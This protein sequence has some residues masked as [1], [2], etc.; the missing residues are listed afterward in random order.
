MRHI[1]FDIEG[2]VPEGT[3]TD[4]ALAT[5]KV[6]CIVAQELESGELGTWGPD[7][8]EAGIAF[9]ARADVLYGHNIAKY[10]LPVFWYLHGFHFTGKVYCT[11]AASHLIYPGPKTMIKQDIIWCRTHPEFPG[12]MI[13]R[14]SLE[15]W[16]HRLHNHKAQY[17]GGFEVYSQE[18]LD[19]CIQD[20]AVNRQLAQL[21]RR[22]GQPDE[23][24]YLESQ[25][26]AILHRME[27][28]G[29]GFNVEEATELMLT[30]STKQE[31]LLTYLQDYY[32]PVWKPNGKVSDPKRDMQ[33]KKYEPGEPG[34]K[35]V[36]VGCKFQNIKLTSF[37]P[38][39]DAQVAERL[40][41]VHGWKPADF[42]D[43]GDPSTKVEII[44][45]LPYETIESLVKYQKVSKVLGYISEGKN[46]WLRLVGTDGRIHGS[47][48]ATGAVTHRKSHKKPNTG[49]VPKVGKFLGRECR[50]LFGVG[51]SGRRVLVGC[52]A[53]GLQLRA[54]A[55]YLAPHDGG[56]F[57][58]AVTEGDPHT[59]MMQG[60]GIIIREDQKTFT[61]AKL[62][63]AWY[64]K[65]GMIK[66]AS[67]R[68]AKEQGLWKGTIPGIDQAVAVGR[69][70]EAGLSELLHMDG[71]DGGLDAAWKRR[72]VFS[73]DGRRVP[74]LSRRQTLNTLLMSFEAVVMKHA[75]VRCDELLAARYEDWEFVL[76]IHD[77]WQIECRSEDSVGV[78]WLMRQAIMEMGTKFNLRCRLDAE[79]KIG[80]NWA[81][82][83]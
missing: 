64:R 65:L 54:L 69:E 9:L 40:I 33:S 75:Q 3:T 55:H 10:D 70:A 78:G 73:L 42:T 28:Y 63:A 29:V 62:F 82:T 43:G 30:L 37:N 67:F 56:A 52:D 19:Y 83:H 58:V 38:G 32:P 23:V 72:Y 17:A 61:Y 79:F 2:L 68:R 36:K 57:A 24:V 74:L 18:M 22:K 8:V 12:Q 53:S 1:V 48:L 4:Y 45:D 25:V 16:G 76:D 49:Q 14:H 41:K 47:M 21:L 13:G 6:H 71:L 7:E 51:D 34:Y 50:Q 59:Y 31:K 60:T 5:R 27:A 35:D 15:A 77:E 66:I 39:S 46:A 80:K 81:D 11:L 20:V 44:E 26:E